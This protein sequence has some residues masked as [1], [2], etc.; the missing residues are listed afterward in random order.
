MTL[1]QLKGLFPLDEPIPGNAVEIALLELQEACAER[2][3]AL[4]EVASG[5]R[6]QI[7]ADVHPWVAPVSYTHLDVYKRQGP[8]RCPRT[9]R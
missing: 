1:V 3:V 7:K 5:W 6:Y 8:A 2:G 9:N 4:V